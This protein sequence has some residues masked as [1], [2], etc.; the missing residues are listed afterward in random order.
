[1]LDQMAD[2]RVPKSEAR[3]SWRIEGQRKGET[4]RLDFGAIDKDLNIFEKR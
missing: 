1:V 4:I 2:G 3:P